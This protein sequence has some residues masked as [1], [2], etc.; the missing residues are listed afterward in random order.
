[1]TRTKSCT[2][3][4][5]ELPLDAFYLKNGKPYP[6]GS[7]IMANWCK[8][9]IK[10]ARR[11]RYDRTSRSGIDRYG[12]TKMRAR[13]FGLEFTIT[14]KYFESLITQPCAYGGG[15]APEIRIGAD[16]KDPAAGYTPENVVPCCQRHNYIKHDFFSFED[17][18][19]IV[20]RYSKA[21]GCGNAKS[22][23]KKLPR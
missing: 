7:G 23:R 19:D 16:R 17:M 2:K 10:V 14:K 4:T 9:C 6:S 21:T 3:C 13:L 11:L 22:G 8:E 1:M 5:K 12:T 20:K 18:I 15:K